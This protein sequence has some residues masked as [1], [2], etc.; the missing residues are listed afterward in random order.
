MTDARALVVRKPGHW[1]W[2][3]GT[4]VLSPL[5]SFQVTSLTSSKNGRQAFEI[6]I[7]GQNSP[8]VSRACKTDFGDF[9][10]ILCGR[11]GRPFLCPFSRPWAL[12]WASVQNLCGRPRAV[13]VM[14]LPQCKHVS[15]T[16]SNKPSKRKGPRKGRNQL[17]WWTLI[18]CA[19]SHS[20]DLP[21]QLS[22]FPRSPVSLPRRASSF[23]TPQ[24][25]VSLTR[26][27][28]WVWR[29]G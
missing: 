13:L 4:L 1:P 11:P 26:S 24:S 12:R 28:G 8:G 20:R 2:E 25:R 22:D 5:V 18:R 10:P 7:S 6:G 21:R 9:S 3:A 19:A 29:P 27:R 23:G 16:A 17:G 14:G 15:T